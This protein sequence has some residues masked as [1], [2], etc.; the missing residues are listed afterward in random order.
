M[1]DMFIEESPN[2][3]FIMVLINAFLLQIFERNPII[4][5]PL[6]NDWWILD[7]G[8]KTSWWLKECYINV[9]PVRSF[10]KI[11]MWVWNR[12]KLDVFEWVHHLLNVLLCFG[13]TFDSLHPSAQ[14]LLFHCSKRKICVH[15]TNYVLVVELLQDVISLLL[16]VSKFD[17]R[18][19]FVLISSFINIV[20]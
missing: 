12:I 17:F 9:S 14:S 1:T 7:W 19:D 13:W 10:E 8:D 3:I 2:L 15:R 6:F 16:L 11:S 4:S 18:F 20:L 5:K